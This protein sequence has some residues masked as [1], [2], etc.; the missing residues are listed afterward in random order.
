M[1]NAKNLINAAAFNGINT[2]VDQTQISLATEPSAN[3]IG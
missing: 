2:V 1:G 3:L